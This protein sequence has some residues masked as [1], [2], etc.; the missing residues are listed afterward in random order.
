MSS[1]IADVILIVHLAFIV[2]V[3]G[4][5]VCVLVGYFRDWPWVRNFTFRVCHL[6]A[7]GI[8]VALA[9]A[10]QVC[11]LTVWENTLRETAG[12]ETYRETFIQHWVG[13]L[14][15]YDAPQWIF[16]A[17]YMAFG[18]LVVLSWYWVRPTR[19]AGNRGPDA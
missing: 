1:L 18:A 6:L 13:E 11:P 19:N 14:V 15:Y 8:V 16:T 9:W 4:G 5:E 12:E 3:L 2:F 17:A 10:N 7:I